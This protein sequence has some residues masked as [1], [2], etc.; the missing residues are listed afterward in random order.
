MKLL[1]CSIPSIPKVKE[2]AEQL[3]SAIREKAEMEGI[4]YIDLTEAL[5]Q[6]EPLI[7]HGRF[8][9]VHYAPSAPRVVARII[10]GVVKPIMGEVDPAEEH[11]RRGHPPYRGRAIHLLERPP[12][13]RGP[14][15]A[16][17]RG[18]GPSPPNRG[19]VVPTMGRPL[20][21]PPTSSR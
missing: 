8:P 13:W 20:I 21:G 19:G 9:G 15:T 7:M 14:T 11:R 2:A 12:L 17:N 16:K 18:C 5:K 4:Q 6:P 3:N 1:I 10:G